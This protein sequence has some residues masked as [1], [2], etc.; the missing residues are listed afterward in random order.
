M[1][2]NISI[3]SIFLVFIIVNVT[4]AVAFNIADYDNQFD[5]VNSDLD[6]INQI[7]NG[8]SALHNLST[9][10]MSDTFW[11]LWYIYWNPGNVLK[12]VDKLNNESNSLINISYKLINDADKMQGVDPPVKIDDP[13]VNALNVQKMLNESGDYAD[14]KQNL[15]IYDLDRSR[16][17]VQFNSSNGYLKY[18]LFKNYVCKNNKWTLEF[19]NGNKKGEEDEVISMSEGDFKKKFKGVVLKPKSSTKP[20]EPSLPMVQ[21][22][23]NSK[24]NQFDEVIKF[25]DYYIDSAEKMKWLGIALGIF[26]LVV[27]VI[28]VP[29][30]AVSGPFAVIV[31]ICFGLVALAL[32]IACAAFEISMYFMNKH[33]TEVKNNIKDEYDDLIKYSP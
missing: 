14:I 17:I 33:A 10:S 5:A 29:V 19:Y 16:D 23:Y 18:W 7:V 26:A 9:M 24:K 11:Y 32:G 30:T 21:K 20:I 22:I 13:I 2:K 12:L 15:T 28:G 25:A 27:P 6:G 8:D 4:P 31:G 1:G 3:L